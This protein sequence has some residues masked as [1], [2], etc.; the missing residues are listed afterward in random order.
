MKKLLL[1]LLLSVGVVIASETPKDDLLSMATM[2][3]D[4]MRDADGGYYRYS[5]YTYTGVGSYYFNV[6]RNAT[7]I[8][9]RA[10]GSYYWGN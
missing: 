5:T 3:K 1:G 10:W 6:N 8:Y 4:D 7:N 9:A 2:V